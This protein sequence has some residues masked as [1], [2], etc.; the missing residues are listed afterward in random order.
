MLSIFSEV[1]SAIN[2][3]GILRTNF[4]F[5]L[6]EVCENLEHANHTIEFLKK[7]QADFQ[8]EMRKQIKQLKEELRDKN[9]ELN[10]YS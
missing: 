8:E 7:N 10:H 2:P 4:K 9:E 1:D 3:N 5:K 6:Q